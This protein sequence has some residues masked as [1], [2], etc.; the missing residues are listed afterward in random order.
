MA[1]L[2][3]GIREVGKLLLVVFTVYV[4]WWTL[5]DLLAFATTLG[6]PASD[7]DKLPLQV[8][9]FW[10]G[11][12]LGLRLLLWILGLAVTQRAIEVMMTRQK[13]GHATRVAMSTAGAAIL[14][15]TI[16]TA[17]GVWSAEGLAKAIGLAV[18]GFV[19]VARLLLCE[20]FEPRRSTSLSVTTVSACF[21]GHTVTAWTAPLSCLQVVWFDSREVSRRRSFRLSARHTFSI[22]DVPYEVTVAKFPCLG[23]RVRRDGEFVARRRNAAQPVADMAI[24]ALL[25]G[26][27]LGGAI[28]MDQSEY[29]SF[30]PPILLFVLVPIVFGLSWELLERRRL[31][32]YAQGRRRTWTCLSLRRYGVAVALVVLSVWALS[33]RPTSS[34]HPYQMACGDGDAPACVFIGNAYWGGQVVERDP[35]KAADFY[36]TACDLG[37]M[38]GCTSLGILYAGGDGVGKDAVKAAALYHKACDAG[39]MRGC[40]ALGLVHE[41]GHGLEKDGEKAIALYHRACK[42]GSARACANLGRIYA[43]GEGVE[44]NPAKVLELYQKACDGGYA[45]GCFV[46]GDMFENAVGVEMDLPRA[47]ALY[48]QSCDGGDDLG[49]FSLAKTYMKGLGVRQDMVMAVHLFEQVC[50]GDDPIGY[51]YG[52]FHVARA[53]ENGMGVDPDPAKAL[54]LYEKACEGGLRCACA[55]LEQ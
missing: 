50:S 41:D 48:R 16:G 24:G 11:H 39:D 40:T 9:I 28:Y 1:H 32:D 7:P 3:K 10:F 52:C 12:T 43:D 13:H 38:R 4:L 35:R 36:R 5:V 54:E 21:D 44:K 29:G 49:C 53:Y 15:G 47:A 33:R 26:I 51:S 22:S 46:L 30:F 14:V 17:T 37:S 8:R 25:V 23:L 55:E 42:G 31:T 27:A 6:S 2:R 34:L 45:F 19:F 20:L 18:V